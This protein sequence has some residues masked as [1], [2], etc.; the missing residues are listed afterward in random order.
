MFAFSN[1]QNKVSSWLPTIQH[2]SISWV[3]LALSGCSEAPTIA[4][5]TI[6]P[7][8]TITVS[9]G[10][11]ADKIVQTGEIRPSEETS[12]GFRIDGRI[13]QRL[14]DV[15]AVVKAG[16]VIAILDPSDSENSLKAAKAQFDSALSAEKLALSNFNRLK[17]LSPGGAVSAAQLEQAQSEHEAAMS[18]RKSAEATLTS[19]RDRLGFTT[20]TAATDGVVSAVAA[21]PGQVVNAGQEIIRLAAL[22]GRDAV[23]D[24]SENLIHS[25]LNHPEVQVTLLSNP[26][27]QAIGHIRDVSP[28]ADPVTRTIRVRVKL[29]NPPT[30]FGFGATVQG[31]IDQPKSTLFKLPASALTR[32]GKESAVYVVNPTSFQ[33]ELKVVSISR[34]TEQ[35]VF[36]STGL[37]GGEHVVVAGVAK[38]RPGMTVR[39]LTE[40]KV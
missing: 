5:D 32:D 38:L 4:N 29:E 34:F 22:T 6:R 3:I 12:L 35:E 14:V 39:L 19:A 28:V 30:A 2:L 36:I 27:I 10:T 16:A 11:D 8:K 25:N 18:A 20:L 15:G 26:S 24:V 17:Q 23:F 33:L 7:V 31:S 21:N 9:A 13:V 40:P 1:V 37:N